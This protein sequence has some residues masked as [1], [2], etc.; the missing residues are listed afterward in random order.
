[1][2]ALLINLYSNRI[3]PAAL[4]FVGHITEVSGFEAGVV[5]LRSRH[6]GAAA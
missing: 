6:R 3:D 4:V 5:F 2:N 1:M